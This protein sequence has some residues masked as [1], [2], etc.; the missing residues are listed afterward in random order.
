VFVAYASKK[1]A[2]FIDR[3]LYLPREWADEPQRREEA[4]VPEEARFATKGE[5]AKRMLRRAFEAEVPA[6][7]VVADTLYGTARGLRRGWLEE[8]RRSYVLAVPE[9]Q[10]VYHAGP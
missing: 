8:Q 5:L 9:T 6:Q 4:Q 1:G 2:T 10:G 3:A 7:W